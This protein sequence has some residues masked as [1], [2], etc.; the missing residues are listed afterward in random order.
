MALLKD[1]GDQVLKL[2]VCV[3]GAACK[4]MPGRGISRRAHGREGT[5]LGWRELACRVKEALAPHALLEVIPEQH[6][7]LRISF[8]RMESKSISE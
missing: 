7:L 1:G 8:G 5:S 2:D 4:A 6:E 3:S